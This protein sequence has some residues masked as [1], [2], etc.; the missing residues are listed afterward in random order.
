[1]KKLHTMSKL[2][3]SLYNADLYKTATVLGNRPL[4]TF[5]KAGR[6]LKSK[7]DLHH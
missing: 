6:V 3:E 7:T 5:L 2:N 4:C 1:M